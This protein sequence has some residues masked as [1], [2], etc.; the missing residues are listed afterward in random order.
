[1]DA[2]QKRQEFIIEL[3]K[4]LLKYKA[5]LTIEDFGEDYS[6]NEK[7]VVNFSYDEDLGR[8]PDFVIGTYMTY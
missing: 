1:M 2:E 7:I 6:P 5:D 3:E 8:I 4:L